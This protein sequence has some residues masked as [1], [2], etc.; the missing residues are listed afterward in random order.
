M[1]KIQDIFFWTIMHDCL[2]FY[3]IIKII[4]KFNSQIQSFSLNKYKFRELKKTHA[5]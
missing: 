4:I 5:D 1:F 3:S 2:R